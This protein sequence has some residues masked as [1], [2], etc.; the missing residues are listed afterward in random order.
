MTEPYLAHPVNA[1]EAAA[2][3]ITVAVVPVVSAVIISRVVNVIADVFVPLD[4]RKERAKFY[5]HSHKVVNESQLSDAAP[6]SFRAVEEDAED[7][8]D[9]SGEESPESSGGDWMDHVERA[10]AELGNAQKKTRCGKCK[11][12]IAEVKGDLEARTGEMVKNAKRHKTMISL[13]NKGKIKPGK[14]WKQLTP[15]EKKMIKSVEN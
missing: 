5:T 1:M 11:K 7:S 6:L 14:T 3:G 10:K 12:D 15:N 2:A 4:E 9:S 13:Q 8:G